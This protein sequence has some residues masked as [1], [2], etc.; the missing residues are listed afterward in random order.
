MGTMASSQAGAAL[1]QPAVPAQH[2]AGKEQQCL[3]SP[4]HSGAP[5][6]AGSAEETSV[7]SGWFVSLPGREWAI[8]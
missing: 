7:F 5:A 3:R 6:P 1:A 2:G 8:H 4:A